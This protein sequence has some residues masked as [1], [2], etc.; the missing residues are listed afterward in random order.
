MDTRDCFVFDPI[1]V[2]ERLNL[3]PG[4]ENVLKKSFYFDPEVYP[5]NYDNYLDSDAI[6]KDPKLMKD[7]K[8]F[9]VGTTT[10][11]NFFSHEEML[12]MER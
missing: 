11:E 6:K 4:R 1:V 12:K 5:D 9:P 7:Y 10:Y 3:G 8:S 2:T